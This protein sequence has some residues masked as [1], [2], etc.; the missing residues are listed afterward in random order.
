MNKAITA[1]V[2][3]TVTVA[4][5][6]LALPAI[7]QAQDVNDHLKC[8]K[9][10]DS[11]KYSAVADLVTNSDQS[12]YPS[13]AGCKIMVKSKEFCLPINKDRIMQPDNKR[14][15]PHEDVVGQDLTNDF[16]C[17]KVRCPRDPTGAMPPSAQDVVD[18]FGQRVIGGFRTI[19]MCTPAWK[20]FDNN[21]QPDLVPVPS[22]LT[23]S[24]CMR[25]AA[26][27]SLLVTVE[28]QG[29]AGAGPT[30][31]SVEF[32]TATG[33]V[34]NS[35]SV[36]ALGAGVSTSVAVPFPVSPN[37]C[38]QPN[39]QFKITVDSTGTELESDETN[40]VASDFCL[41]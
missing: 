6:A 29:A 21:D 34:T 3:A 16:L 32:Q 11:H 18:Q 35:V 39:C 4:F 41:G 31:V 8:Y 17:Y 24:F 12:M 14:D 15:A 1:I 37:W 5:L 2:T 23:G 36:P 27:A 33:P 30:Q 25:D 26:A 19:R 28:N 7:S 13:E 38:Y 20:V 22:P 10:K 9:I 40:N